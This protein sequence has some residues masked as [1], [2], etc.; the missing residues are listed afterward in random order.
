LSQRGAQRGALVQGLE[1]YIHRLQP[2][3]WDHAFCIEGR[4][5]SELPEALLGSARGIHWDFHEVHNFPAS[6]TDEPHDSDMEACLVA[7]TRYH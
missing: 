2:A 5:D 4:K 6:L 7:V 3:V 1:G